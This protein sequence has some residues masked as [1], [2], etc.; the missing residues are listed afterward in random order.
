MKRGKILTRL[1]E[2]RTE[3]EIFLIG[4]KNRSKSLEFNSDIF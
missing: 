3:V 2:F 1:F 4:K